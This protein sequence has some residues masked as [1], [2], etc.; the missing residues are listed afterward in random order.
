[1]KTIDERDTHKRRLL[2]GLEG[3]AHPLP[4]IRAQCAKI[5]GDIGDS[6]A[7]EALKRVSLSES[8]ILCKTEMI[9]AAVALEKR[10]GLGNGESPLLEGASP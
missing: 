2:D 6:D 1:M 7:L 4:Q 3:L 5:L 10:L 8:N 9:R